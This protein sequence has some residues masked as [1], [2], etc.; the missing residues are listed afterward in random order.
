MLCIY[1]KSY[2]YAIIAGLWWGYNIGATVL[3]VSL[4]LFIALLNWQTE[5]NNVSLGLFLLVFY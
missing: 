1:N 3:A 4:L 2:V 5:A